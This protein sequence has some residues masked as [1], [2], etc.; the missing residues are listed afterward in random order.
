MAFEGTKIRSTRNA[1]TPIDG[2]RED[3]AAGETI[4][5]SLTNLPQTPASYEW[6][7]YG[8]PEGSTVGGGGTNPWLLG[9]GA[10]CA[11]TV[12]ADGTN[13]GLDGSYQIQC[14][15]NKGST[16]ETRFSVTLARPTTVQL[17][18]LSGNRTL[19]KLGMFESLE[20]T[21]SQPGVLAGWFTHMA[22]W[23]EWFRIGRGRSS[24][25]AS[26]TNLLLPPAFGYIEV[27]GTTQIDYMRITGR[28]IGESWKIRFV[29]ALT[30]RH[31]IGSVPAGSAALNLPSG[32]NLSVTANSVRE[33]VYNGTVV[34]ECGGKAG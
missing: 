33:F 29:S 11:F 27:T 18:G 17:P 19:R 31:N 16:L 21:G 5:C 26:A 30:L 25:V 20:D 10:S 8:R 14:T 6:I 7:C 2:Y 1:A 15:V 32:S 4:A 22:R 34:H 12:D 24:D 9:T 3:L 13:V 28:Q 23:L